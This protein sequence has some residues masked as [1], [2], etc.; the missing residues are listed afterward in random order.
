[1]ISIFFATALA[2]LPGAEHVPQDGA[3]VDEWV[4]WAQK[5]PVSAADEEAA[6]L[7]E[8]AAVALN[9]WLGQAAYAH[10]QSEIIKERVRAFHSFMENRGSVL[11][12]SWLAGGA[13]SVQDR[14]Y[15]PLLKAV[16][17]RAYFDKMLFRVSE[18]AALDEADRRLWQEMRDLIL[19]GH[20]ALRAAYLGESLTAKRVADLYDFALYWDLRHTGTIMLPF[21]LGLGPGTAPV[22]G[23]MAPAMRLPRWDFAL[24]LPE[25]RDE[26]P[27][28]IS[29][30]FSPRLLVPWL[31]AIAA[32]QP[33]AT[34]DQVE[35]RPVQWPDF[36]GDAWVTLE[37]F[38]GKQPV[39]LIF[40]DPTD[41]WGWHFTIALMLESLYLAYRE[42]CAFF[43]IH[44]GNRESYTGVRD[45]YN[46]PLLLSANQLSLAHPA[47]QLAERARAA[48]MFYLDHPTFT[49]PFLLDDPGQQTRNAWHDAGTSAAFCLIDR[50][51]RVAWYDR[52][53]DYAS[54]SLPFYTEFRERR[55]NA[56]EDR[57][58]ALLE[59]GGLAE[60][61][62]ERPLPEWRSRRLDTGEIQGVNPTEG[63]IRLRTNQGVETFALAPFTRLS[64]NGDPLILTDFSQG[65]SVRLTFSPIDNTHPTGQLI[66]VEAAPKSVRLMWITGEILSTNAE[67][68]TLEIALDRLDGA[69]S[70]GLRWWQTVPE[71]MKAKHP[72]THAMQR[73][74]A[75]LNAEPVKRTFL[76]DAASWIFV[77]GLIAQFDEI[78]PGDR[79]GV[80]YPLSEDENES[81][82]AD[83]LRVSRPPQ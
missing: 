40:T 37:E 44:S 42:K 77:N 69:E 51:G 61:V 1:M 16:R 79:V 29:S 57:L 55:L 75:R 35:N 36:P 68:R 25:Y 5:A 8:G 23:E 82:R 13:P 56:W 18:P 31:L 34:G 83:H 52:L 2:F 66:A 64:R 81:F 11:M 49:L 65:E 32:Y 67:T 80:G 63:L 47:V 73:A 7:A 71:H 22:A 15:L 6:M 28:E 54:E 74:S 21:Q 60:A 30:L 41:A 24:R 38:R 3:A 39:V 27:L 58:R 62:R 19:A 26:N 4:E 59:G 14:V 10:H 17:M 46:E 78:Q 12:E 9:A 76:I 50:E 20:S 33:T 70:P 48:K 45:F 72:E 43:L 53:Q